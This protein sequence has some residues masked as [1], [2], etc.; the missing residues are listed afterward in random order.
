MVG[1]IVLSPTG[2][3]SQEPVVDSA[4]RVVVA[5][6]R[7]PRDTAVDHCLEDLGTKHPDLELEGM[8]VCMCYRGERWFL[9]LRVP[10]ILVRLNKGS[11]H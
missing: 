9:Q 5:S 11:S 3:A 2:A 7:A 10:M 8:Y 6:A 1:A 4:Q